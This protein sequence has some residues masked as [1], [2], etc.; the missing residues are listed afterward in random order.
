MFI[1]THMYRLASLKS[2]QIWPLSLSPAGPSWAV[3]ACL[4]WQALCHHPDPCQYF[5]FQYWL[6]WITL[7]VLGAR[8]FPELP[9]ELHFWIPGNR[10]EGWQMGRE[11]R[12]R[13]ALCALSAILASEALP[14]QDLCSS[15]MFGLGCPFPVLCQRRHLLLQTQSKGHTSLRWGLPRRL[16]GKEFA[17]QSGDLGLIP[18][19]GR[20]PREG[21]GNPL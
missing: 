4:R 18:G 11:P 7:L 20:C 9:S 12:D 5:R 2:P 10:R 3:A 19:S 8:L 15:W 14:C 21:N 1:H 17:C 6:I 13:G 16:S